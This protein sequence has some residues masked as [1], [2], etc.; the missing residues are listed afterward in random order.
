MSCVKQSEHELW[1]WQAFF[2]EISTFLSSS[3]VDSLDIVQSNMPTMLWRDLKCLC[4]VY[5]DI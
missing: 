5:L 4:K 1:R 2:E 3:I